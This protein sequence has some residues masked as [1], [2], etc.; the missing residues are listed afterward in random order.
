MYLALPA[1]RTLLIAGGVLLVLAV[2]IALPFFSPARGVERAWDDVLEAIQ[3][4]DGEA[5]GELLGEDYADGFGLNRA[6]AL[7]LAAAVR[8]HFVVCSVRRV[9]SELIMDPSGKSAVSRGLI[10]LGGNGSPVAQSAIHASE[11][12]QTP[13][14]F[15]WRRNSWKPWDWRLVS[16]DNPD[17]ARGLSRFQREA[18]AMGLLP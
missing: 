2:L 11:A 7:K 15:R 14:A 16:V 12:S 4:N 3:D 6:E 13:T 10:R 17:A 9:S 5:L 1:R 18:G 8:G